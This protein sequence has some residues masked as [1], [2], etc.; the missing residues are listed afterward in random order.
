MFKYLTLPDLLDIA[1]QRKEPPFVL[2]LD[3]IEDPH[4]FGAILRTAEA[5]GVHGVVIRKNRQVPVTETVIKV[6]T[7]AA[8]NVPIARVPNIAEAIRFLRNESLTVF[9]VEIDGKRL[10]NQADYRSGVALVVGSE[11]AGLARLVKERC[12]E[13]VRLPMRGKV[14]SLNASV[15]TGIV[16]YEV[17][18]QR[19]LD[20][21]RDK[22][23]EL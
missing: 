6:S 12:D 15:A 20:E 19:S 8:E 9:G 11:G 16:L 7:G 14:N 5:A 21:S 3:G 1:A 17:L 18:R 23:G 4:N 13:V 2:I 10:Y 22:G